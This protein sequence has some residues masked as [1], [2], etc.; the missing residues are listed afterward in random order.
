MNNIQYISA[1]K[2]NLYFNNIKHHNFLYD[3]LDQYG[4]VVNWYKKQGYELEKIK[5]AKIQQLL[6]KKYLNSSDGEKIEPKKIGFWEHGIKNNIFDVQSDMIVIDCLNNP[7]CNEK[8]FI[9]IYYEIMN[10]FKQDNIDII[11]VIND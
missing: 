10:E 8:W 1:S 4:F 5:D 9:D 11:K 3:V 6:Y 2:I 7:I